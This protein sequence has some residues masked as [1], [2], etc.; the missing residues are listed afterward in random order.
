M[1]AM[2][3]EKFSRDGY[4]FG[5]NPN[6]YIAKS[7]ILLKAK[8]SVLCLGEG[9]GRN[10][11]FLAKNDFNVTAI[12]AS[13]VGLQKA[14]ELASK[15]NCS[16]NTEQ[17]DLNYWKPK[18]NTY[19]AIVSSYL[20]LEEPLRSQTFKSII[21]ALSIDGIFIGEFFSKEQL[22][23]NSGGPKN[24][25]LLYDIDSIESILENEKI[26]IIELTKE[27]THLNEGK[28]HQGEASVVRICFQKV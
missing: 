27:L 15:H 9:E 1:R 3:D 6:A 25:S 20:H 12:D 8:S 17:L 28:G 24:S 19:A 21:Y 7:S 16:I 26:K 13:D 11:L 18:E 14:K 2:W 23:F 10:A 4:L 22:N 5:T